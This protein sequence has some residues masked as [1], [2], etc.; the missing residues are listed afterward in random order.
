M[1]ASALLKNLPQAFTPD[2]ATGA[3][4]TPLDV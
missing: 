3:E 1:S 4:A 2:A